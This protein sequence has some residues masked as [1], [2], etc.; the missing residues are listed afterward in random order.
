VTNEP[1]YGDSKGSIETTVTVGVPDFT[2]YWSNGYTTKDLTDVIAG[3]YSVTVTDSHQCTATGSWTITEPDS[4]SVSL[5]LTH[6]HCYTYSEGSITTSVTGGTPDYTYQWSTPPGSTTPDIYN[7]AAGT[8]TV[9]VTDSHGCI[10]TGVGTI[11]EPEPWGPCISGPTVACQGSFQTYCICQQPT[12]FEGSTYEWTVIGGTITNGCCGICKTIIW[13]HCLVGKVC[14]T[15]TRADGCMMTT[16]IDVTLNPV[17]TPVITGP[18]TVYPDSTTTYTTT[19][20]ECYLYSWSVIGGNVIAGM[21]TNTITV[22]WDQCGPCNPGLIKVCVTDNCLATSCCGCTTLDINILASPAPKIQGYVTYKND[23]VTGGF[24]TPLN[25]VTVYLWNANNNIVGTCITGPNFNSMGEAGY[26]AFNNVPDGN[27]RL[28]ASF[29]GL[30]GGNN[31]TD[32]L[33]VQL[34]CIGSYPLHGLDSIVADVNGS[35]TTT[36][37]DAL[38]IKLR[39]VGMITSYPAGDWKFTDISF[40]LTAPMTQDLQGLC[41]GDVNDSYIPTGLKQASF[42]AP[43]DG[44]IMTIPVNESFNYSI[45]SNT[46][47]KLGAMTL[48]MSYDPNRFEIEKVVTSLEGMKYVIDH[49]QVSLAW[50]DTKSLLMKSDSDYFTAD[51]SKRSDHTAYT[52]LLDQPGQRIC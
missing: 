37:L 32:A 40:T 13:D 42:L 43:V 49:G 44:G 45:K 31:A 8:Y 2:Y 29:N 36:A 39:T 21:G 11:T 28:T 34:N 4:L 22:K 30:W 5:T 7:L 26:Y 9:T 10:T 14:V 20:N 47:S 25:G 16:C 19:Y 17:P 41:V 35:M 46:I 12:Q 27:Y 6:N 1:C 33:I 51:E 50:S 18:I 38:Y 48:F 15:E 24:P 3:T 52:D 23:V